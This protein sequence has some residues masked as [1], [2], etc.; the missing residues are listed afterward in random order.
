MAAWLLPRYWPRL[1]LRLRRALATAFIASTLVALASVFTP[2]SLRGFWPQAVN[3]LLGFLSATCLLVL[4]LR[5]AH[6]RQPWTGLRPFAVVAA[7]L[8]YYALWVVYWRSELP[9]AETRLTDQI[10]LRRTSGGWAGI[11][12]EGV[13]IVEQPRRFPFLERVLYSQHIG[14]TS[15]CDRNS[16]H[17]TPDD[18]SRTIRVTCG[19][20]DV[21]VWATVRMP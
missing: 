17:V 16:L 7:M 12:W 5:S 19:V 1:G 14:E 2:W 15:D 8:M 9:V 20:R 18:A 11:G 4:S 3:L 13:T 21:A 10:V 6:G